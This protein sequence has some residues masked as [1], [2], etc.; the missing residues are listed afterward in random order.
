MINSH[1]E[2][3]ITGDNHLLI[4]LHGSVD[5]EKLQQI[6]ADIKS[7]VNK[8]YTYIPID[9]SEIDSI[10]SSNISML[11]NTCSYAHDDGVDICLYYPPDEYEPMLCEEAEK[12]YFEIVSGLNDD[13]HIKSDTVHDG[14]SISKFTIPAKADNVST[15]RN[16][17]IRLARTMS[18]SDQQLEDITLAVGE[19]VSN[20][21]KHGSPDGERCKVNVRC[22]RTADGLSIKI[23]DE[24]YGFDPS[25][26]IKSPPSRLEEGGRGIF[27]MRVMM[28]EVN[29]FF[30]HGTT[31]ELEKYL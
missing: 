2:I 7:L 17:V 27:F 9:C 16:K 11:T 10:D 23:T 20:A 15:A 14:W 6:C 12:G 31:V 30:N 8:G 26:C 4:K 3:E 1:S 29:F 22:E 25:A 28:D 18:F 24:G 19:A 21:V 13:N 5:R